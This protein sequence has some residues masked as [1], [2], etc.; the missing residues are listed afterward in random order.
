MVTVLVVWITV[1]NVWMT[2]LALFVLINTSTTT[3]CVT[4]ALMDVASVPNRS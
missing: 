3:P 4:Y 2:K 1:H